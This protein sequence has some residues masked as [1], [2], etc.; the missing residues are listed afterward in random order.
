MHH[1]VQTFG[2]R[3]VL[4]R[5]DHCQRL[6]DTVLSPILARYGHDPAILA[7]DII[8][9]PDLATRGLWPSLPP[10][11]IGQGRMQSFIRRA[12]ALI[13]DLTDQGATVGLASASRLD[14]VR[15]LGLDLYQ[16][17][18]YDANDALSALETPV[19]AFGL[20]GPIILGEFPTR[21]S[22]RAPEQIYS[23]AREAGYA[24]VLPWSLL[25]RDSSTDRRACETFLAWA[26][27][28]RAR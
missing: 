12:A 11:A 19:T 20:D 28:E 6:L 16:A 10:T 13:H 5:P 21:N 23:T 25:A 9:E 8:N 26:G 17:H 18:W 3:E 2:R 24:G 22:E 4:R 7:W 14:F 1:G 15:D 27:G